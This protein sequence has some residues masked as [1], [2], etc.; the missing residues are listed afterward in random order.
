MTQARANPEAGE[1]LK[2]K[3][4]MKPP[5]PEDEG[6]QKWS[7]NINHVEIRYNRNIKTGEV[8]DFKFK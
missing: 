4:D 8:D 5:W 6:W 2:L 1:P 7:Q 3:G